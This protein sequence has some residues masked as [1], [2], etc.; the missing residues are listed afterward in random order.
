MAISSGSDG[1]LYVWEK[2]QLVRR[3][4]A[5]P[6]YEVLSLYAATNSKIIASG[7]TNGR[8]IIWKVW[9]SQII[10]HQSEYPSKEGNLKFP[11][12]GISMTRESL[13]VGDTSGAI[14]EFGFGSVDGS[15]YE[16]L[17]AP[18]DHEEINSCAFSTSSKRLYVITDAQ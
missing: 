17:L 11:I 15:G 4:N 1:Y 14:M 9:S 6:G 18:F 13:V 16:T 10:N 5:H 2:G 12:Q 3:Q 7:G 8:V